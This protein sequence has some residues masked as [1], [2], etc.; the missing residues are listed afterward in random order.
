MINNFLRIARLVVSNK[1]IK[2]TRLMNVLQWNEMIKA[3]NDKRL[4]KYRNIESSCYWM[5]MTYGEYIKK[6][7]DSKNNF[8]NK[9]PKFPKEFEFLDVRTPATNQDYNDVNIRVCINSKIWSEININGIE[10]CK[11]ANIEFEVVFEEYAQIN[12]RLAGLLSKKLNIDTEICSSLLSDDSFYGLC[13][14]YNK[15]AKQYTNS[16]FSFSIEDDEKYKQFTFKI[17]T[18]SFVINILNTVAEAKANEIEM[19]ES[20]KEII[21]DVQGMIQGIAFAKEKLKEITSVYEQVM[22]NYYSILTETKNY[23]NG[24]SYRSNSLQNA[25]VK[26]N[27]VNYYVEGVLDLRTCHE[28]AFDQYLQACND[29]LELK[30]IAPKHYKEEVFNNAIERLEKY[31]EEYDEILIASRKRIDDI[32]KYITNAWNQDINLKKMIVEIVFNSTK[33]KWIN[34]AR[35]K[36][37]N[38]F[39]DFKKFC[40]VYIEFVKK[41]FNEAIEIKAEQEISE[42]IN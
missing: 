29:Y 11:N 3:Y 37:M 1:A 5:D 38:D 33:A 8:A 21:A 18:T 10:N 12:N 16:N 40:E 30:E 14:F 24:Y 22:G 6:K 36:I 20:R 26:G 2:K 23:I 7:N 28:Y 13:K 41:H 15:N 4:K 32:R 34:R 42:A 31:K 9:K 25:I 35:K 27:F 39:K 17:D 19:I